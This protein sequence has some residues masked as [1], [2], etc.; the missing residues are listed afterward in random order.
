MTDLTLV[1]IFCAAFLVVSLL[2]YKWV[3]PELM[4]LPRSARFRA[5]Q[6]AQMAVA[7]RSPATIVALVVL[8]VAW[9]IMEMRVG[10]AY[11]QSAL[12]L[13]VV[14]ILLLFKDRTA[15]RRMLRELLV[16][17]GLCICLACGHMLQADSRLPCPQCGAS[18]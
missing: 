4:L 16:E 17:D 7:Y 5:F 1:L 8:G 14:I 6:R 15:V 18:R 2:I 10:L 12:A 13:L 9:G 11:W 3:F